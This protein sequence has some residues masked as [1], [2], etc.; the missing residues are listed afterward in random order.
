M[1]RKRYS[2]AATGLLRQRDILLA[3]E[4]AGRQFAVAHHLHHRVRRRGPGDRTAPLASNIRG[5]I[6][7]HKLIALQLALDGSFRGDAHEDDA[8]VDQRLGV[9]RKSP[10]SSAVIAA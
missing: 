3:Q 1:Q 10:A 2:P 7:M 4:A 5:P 6:G 8:E 9:T